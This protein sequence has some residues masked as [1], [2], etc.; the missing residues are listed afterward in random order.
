LLQNIRL[1]VE[2]DGSFYH[3]WQKQ[4]CLPTVQGQLEEVLSVFF[5]TETHLTAAGRTDAGVHA[6]GQVANF[7]VDTCLSP[8]TIMSAINH[9]LPVSIRIRKT[10]STSLDFHSQKDACYRLYAY[11]IYNRRVS[12]P[13]YHPYTWW[14]VH[15]LNINLMRGAA[16]FLV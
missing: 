13:F 7:L 15:S 12:S 2:Y 11:V 8:S 14:V 16:R 6:K 3:G 10:E 5:G 4:L 9:Y 1:V